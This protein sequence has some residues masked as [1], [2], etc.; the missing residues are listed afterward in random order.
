MR[1]QSMGIQHI[2]LQQRTSMHIFSYQAIVAYI[3]RTTKQVYKD[4]IN[5]QHHHHHHYH[6]CRHHHIPSIWGQLVSSA[7]LLHSSFHRTKFYNNPLP[8]GF[9]SFSFMNCIVTVFSFQEIYVFSFAYLSF[10]TH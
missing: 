8:N 6:H 3:V 10:N 9:F 1:I 4:N 7:L 5:R 2:E